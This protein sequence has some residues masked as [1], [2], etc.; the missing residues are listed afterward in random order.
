MPVD[1]I[2]DGAPTPSVEAM[3]EEECLLLLGREPVGRLALTSGALPV[4]LPVNFAL[5]GR[6]IVFA[7]APGLKLDAAHSGTVVCLEVDG[8]DVLSHTGWS[9]LATGRLAEITDP[10][11]LEEAQRL[12]LSPWAVSDPLHYVQLGIE[13]LSGRRIVRPSSAP[14]SEGVLA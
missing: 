1:R 14:T 13:L 10:V 6:T 5:R 12:P 9:V 7:S 2:A 3:S 8:F 4:V 11:R